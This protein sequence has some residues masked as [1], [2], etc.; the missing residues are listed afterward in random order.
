MMAISA[1]MLLSMIALEFVFNSNVNYKVALNEKERLQAYYLALSELNLMKVELKLD[2]QIKST[3]ASMPMLQNLPIDLSQPICSQMP[4]STGLIRGFFV[5]GEMPLM[6]GASTAPEAEK[7]PAAA[8]PDTGTTATEFEAENAQ[9][10]LSF[11]GDFDGSCA[12]ESAKMNLNVWATLDPAQQLLAG[13]NPYDMY[14]I[15]LSNFFKQDRFKKLFEG[16]TPDK[17]DES[18]RNIADWVDKNDVINDLGGITRGSEQS[19]YKEDDRPKPKNGKFLSLDEVHLVEGVDDTWFVPLEDSFTVYGDAKV[20]VCV[21]DDDVIWALVMTYA[22]Q[23]TA[24]PPINPKNIELKKKVIDTMKLSCMGAQPQVGKIASDVD[25]ALG[26]GTAAQTTN[27][28][29]TGAAQATGG[30][31]SYI[32]TEPRYYSLKL[33]GQV[34]DTMVNIKTVIDVKDSDPKKWRMLYYKVF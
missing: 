6:K 23:N 8:K 18:V 13:N 3:V 12:D 11:D 16:V 25:A 32:T 27:P 21:A 9:K 31:A 7:K 20:N 33:T 30:F 34:G 29:A 28:Q 5:G 15:A 4:I 19:L 24:I 2:K 22:S 14:K 1:I 26:L 10:F 17:M